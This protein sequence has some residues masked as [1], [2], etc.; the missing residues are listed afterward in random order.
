MPINT[1][2]HRGGD[3]QRT[4][5]RRPPGNRSS[6][7][8][9]VR[10]PGAVTRS[11]FHSLELF[12]RTS[13]IAQSLARRVVLIKPPYYQTSFRW[14]P[15]ARSRRGRPPPARRLHTSSDL[16]TPVVCSAI[17]VEGAVLRI[18]TATGLHQC[19]ASTSLPSQRSASLR[20]RLGCERRTRK[21][22]SAQ[23]GA[24][25][26]MQTVNAVGANARPACIAIQGKPSQDSRSGLPCRQYW[27]ETVAPHRQLIWLRG[28]VAALT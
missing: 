21:W 3:N 11:S 10:P 22:H 23:S 15:R 26:K 25:L 17:A 4:Y 12:S 1:S 7:A 8:G 24:A 2:T 20:H 28:A 13:S 18:P 6:P 19:S 9:R 14:R 16:R 27:L 5:T